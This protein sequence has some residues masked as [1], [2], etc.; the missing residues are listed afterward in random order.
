MVTE[1]P[2]DLIPLIVIP[3]EPQE[4]ILYDHYCKYV[5]FADELLFEC[6][7]RRQ[8]LPRSNQVKLSHTFEIKLIYFRIWNW[9][10]FAHLVTPS[11]LTRIA[12]FK[13]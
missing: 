4:E 1:P 5:S 6:T 13:L 8:S 11:P 3:S 10:G 12:L 2:R 9:Y 7:I